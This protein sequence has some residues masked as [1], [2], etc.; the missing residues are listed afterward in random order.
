MRASC[1][2]DLSCSRRILISAE[3]KKNQMEYHFTSLENAAICTCCSNSTRW[4][5]NKSGLERSTPRMMQSARLDAVW[6]PRRS[7]FRYVSRWFGGLEG[8]GR[9]NVQVLDGECDSFRGEC[10][11]CHRLAYTPPSV[12][13]W[14]STKGHFDKKKKP[15]V[16]KSGSLTPLI[17][18]LLIENNTFECFTCVGVY[19]C[20][21]F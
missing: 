11:H 14:S 5:S 17:S 3:E 12:T 21:A 13:W 9:G 2:T 18:V 6:S 20:Q 19:V 8:N 4:L 15:T 1:G 16:Q 10:R 7:L